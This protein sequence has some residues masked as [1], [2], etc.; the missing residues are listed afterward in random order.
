MANNLAAYTPL[1]EAAALDAVG[2]SLAFLSDFTTDFTNEII[3]FRKSTVKVPLLSGSS[4][5]LNPTSFGGGS[6][7]STM[8]SIAMDHVS[9][10]FYVSNAEYQNG[11]KLE[12]LIKSNVQVLADKIQQLAFTPITSSNFATAATVTQAN[13]ALSSLQAGWA[14]I[15]GSRKV[16]YVDGT[17]FSKLLTNQNTYVDPT[18]GIPYAG[19]QKVAYTDV[20]TGM[21][22]NCYGFCSADKKGLVMASGR[23][24]IAPGAQALINTMSID[25]G[26]GLV[27]DLNMWG[28]TSD[29]SDNASLD[30]YFGAA[31]GD[32]TALTLFKSA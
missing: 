7:G 2:N 16:A 28:S 6:N 12:Q 19:F 20:V 25:L 8:I 30:L 23:A 13:F 22:T 11:Y 10:P 21:G 24:A 31:A 4:A 3:D 17:A 5:V 1:I 14:S 26:N 18:L 29:R 32:K 15:K 27:A 9:V